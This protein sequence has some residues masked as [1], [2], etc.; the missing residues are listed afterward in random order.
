MER[1]EEEADR[2]V[3]FDVEDMEDIEGEKEEEAPFLSSTRV[4]DNDSLRNSRNSSSNR[5]S[6][7]RS[8]VR[9]PIPRTYVS[10]FFFFS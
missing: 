9:V 7:N 10:R 6:E 3:R 8:S 5:Q 2:R 1:K 4:I